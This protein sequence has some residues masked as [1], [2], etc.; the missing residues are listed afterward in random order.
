MSTTFNETLCIFIA[1]CMS[2]VGREV[3]KRVAI[4]KM[5]F[6]AN[7]LFKKFPSTPENVSEVKAIILQMIRL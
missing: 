6:S 5:A 7:S 1:D 3:N 4:K 2:V